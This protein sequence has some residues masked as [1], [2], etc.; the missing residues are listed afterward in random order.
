MPLIENSFMADRGVAKFY[1]ELH[2]SKFASLYQDILN[3]TD[4]GVLCKFHLEVIMNTWSFG[5][6][7]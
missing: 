5:A 6:E 3:K 1:I 2:I 7:K 4:V